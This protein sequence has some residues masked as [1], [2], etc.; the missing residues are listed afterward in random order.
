MKKYITEIR[1]YNRKNITAMKNTLIT[2]TR[3]IIL[4]K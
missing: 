3:K 2:E 4:L 1:K